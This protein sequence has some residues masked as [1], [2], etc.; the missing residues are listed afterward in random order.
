VKERKSFELVGA[1][2]QKGCQMKVACGEDVIAC[3]VQAV[4]KLGRA[5][6]CKEHAEY[7]SSFMSF[8]GTDRKLLKELLDEQ[9]K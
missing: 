1:E 9:P 2:K 8:S 3:G 4:A 5:Y 7:A 6:V